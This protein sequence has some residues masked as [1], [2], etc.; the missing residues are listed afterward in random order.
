MRFAVGWV[1]LVTGRDPVVATAGRYAGCRETLRLMWRA[2][3]TADLVVATSVILG[4]SL[5]LPL[6]V[7]LGD[8]AAIAT[9][10][11]PALERS[12]IKLHSRSF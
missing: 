10:A 3:G 4:P 9:P 2:T 12:P 7:R 5:P 11:G 8:I 6:M 1:A